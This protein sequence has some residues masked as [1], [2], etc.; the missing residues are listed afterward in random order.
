[1]II[2]F[3]LQELLLALIFVALVLIWARLRV[4]TRAQ[5]NEVERRLD[6]FLSASLNS[7]IK[8]TTRPEITPI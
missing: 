8:W 6:N 3:T 1:M 2:Y 7:N 5:K 4:L